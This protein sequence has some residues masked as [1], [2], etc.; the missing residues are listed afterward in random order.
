[1]NV[2]AAAMVSVVTAAIVELSR[3]LSVPG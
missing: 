3:G 1:M 2:T